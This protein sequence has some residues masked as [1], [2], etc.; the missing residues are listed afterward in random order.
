MV[1]TLS[2]HGKE[3]EGAIKFSK[4]FSCVKCMEKIAVKTII[5]LTCVHEDKSYDQ[6]FQNPVGHVIHGVITVF[7]CTREITVSAAYFAVYVDVR[8]GC[9]DRML[10]C[11]IF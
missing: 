4:L 5:P 1:V 10:T 9:C 3:N 2:S 11:V 7:S 6:H 8:D